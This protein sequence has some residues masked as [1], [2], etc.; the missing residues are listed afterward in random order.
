MEWIIDKVDTSI[1]KKSLNVILTGI[2][3]CIWMLFITSIITNYSIFDFKRP[4]Y[5]RVDLLGK[6]F[7]ICILAPLIE[8][9]VFRYAP[10]TIAKNAGRKYILPTMIISSFI[11]GVLHPNSPSPLLMQGVAGFILSCIYLKN[12]NSY[13]SAVMVHFMWNF[14]FYI[15]MFLI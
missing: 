1:E 7:K 4:S 13:C 9:L 14:F 3:I 15:L 8:E 10:L 2:F 5:E 11:F 12:N 6:F